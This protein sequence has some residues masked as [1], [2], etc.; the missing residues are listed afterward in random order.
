MLL[1]RCALCKQ[2][3]SVERLGAGDALLT[4]LGLNKPPTTLHCSVHKS[5]DEALVTPGGRKIK[6]DKQSHFCSGTEFPNF[7]DRTYGFSAIAK[8]Q[9]GKKNAFAMPMQIMQPSITLFAHLMLQ[10]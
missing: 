3:W 10:L 4:R 2:D 6:T 9:A 7:A 5:H 1:H 8:T